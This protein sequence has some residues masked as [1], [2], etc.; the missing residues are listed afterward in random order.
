[1]GDLN[2]YTSAHT[3]LFIWGRGKVGKTILASQFPNPVF[4]CCKEDGLKSVR[5]MK[6]LYRLDFNFDRFLI[7]ETET[8][9]PDFVKLCTSAFTKMH[10]WVKI[11]KLVERLCKGLP[12]DSF[13]ILDHYTNLCDMLI[14]HIETKNGTSMRIQ[15]WGEFIDEMTTLLDYMKSSAT[16]CSSIVLFHDEHIKDDISGKVFRNVL[17]PTKL[18]HTLASVP[19]EYLYM[20][21]TTIAGKT[22]R[23]L[24]AVGDSSTNT[25]SYSLMPDIEDPTYKKIKPYLERS[26]G[27][28]LPEPTWTP[29]DSK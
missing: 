5:S 8:T 6:S 27:R 4:I 9:D 23:V 2:G 20:H 18:K 12:A 28:S 16:K 29:P 19:D 1:M 11:K 24:Q 25:G 14:H 21:A 22:K 13:I 26:L 10:G 17:S 3:M 7:E 15:D